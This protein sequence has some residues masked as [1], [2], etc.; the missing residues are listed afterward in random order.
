MSLN[1][2]SSS[3]LGAFRRTTLVIALGLCAAS[4][5]ILAHAADDKALQAQLQSLAERLQKLEQRNIELERLMKDQQAKEQATLKITPAS[6]AANPDTARLER[7]ES[8]STALQ[9]RV[10]DLAPAAA[11]GDDEAPKFTATLLSVAQTA[12]AAG[13]ATGARQSRLNYRGDITA[14]L[15]AG[16]FGDAKGTVFGQLRFG[17]GTGV[18]L[19]P[20]HSSTPNSVGFETSAG[21]D[22]SFAI[23]AQAYYQLEVPLGNAGFN[24]GT[25]NRLLF[26]VG[27]MDLFGLFD[28]NEVAADEG[29][30]FINN[31]F[32]HNPLLDSGGDIAADAYGFAPGLRIGYF[33]RSDANLSYGASLGVFAA[34]NDK[35]L[36]NNT[37]ANFSGDIKKPLIIAQFELSPK[38]INGDSRGNYRFY[39]WSNGG[40]T[41]FAD[42]E[43]GL[44]AQ[45]RHT[46]VGMSIDQKIGRD[47]NVFGRFGRR[48]S[49]DGAFDTALTGG[50][51]IGG[52][53]WGRNKDSLG[54]AYGILRTSN[55]Y[56]E[57]TAANVAAGNATSTFEATG[58]E[59]IAEIYYRIKMNDHLELTPNFQLIQRPGGDGSAASVRVFGLRGNVSF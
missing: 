11:A 9:Q 40:T 58:N 18:G 54:L 14:Q 3:G 1:S 35:S 7:L 37:G 22:D 36:G 21:P 50:V 43:T 17:Q 52:K 51:E 23:L 44:S 29:A 12:N 25:G 39:A 48:L 34:G 49:G 8:Q 13:S 33:S 38:Q 30:K 45:Q 55:A 15:N 10:N 42:P 5:P 41:G 19:I 28:Q 20:T 2:S 31:V 4:L 16:S 6:T 59:R 24:S 57:Y 32:V 47:F 46:G 27:K 26:N 56:R 53:A